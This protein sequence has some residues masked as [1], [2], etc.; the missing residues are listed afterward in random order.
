VRLLDNR[1]YGLG[2]P[3]L[4]AFAHLAFIASDLTFLNAGEVYLL[5]FLG[6]VC[7]SCLDGASPLLAARLAF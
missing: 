1:N 2:L 6:H 7:W 4:L 3:A 5:G